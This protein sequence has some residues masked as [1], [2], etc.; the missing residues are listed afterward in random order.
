[1]NTH[2]IDQSI[3][4]KWE[5][6]EYGRSEEHVAVAP[7]SAHAALDEGLAMKLVSIRLPI[8]LIEGLKKIAE[9]H[10]IAYQPMVRDLLTRFAQSEV[11]EIIRGLDEKMKAV[12]AE[13]ESSPPVEAFM[14][15]TRMTACG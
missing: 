2:P 14:E 9:H 12:R 5:E 6:G 3:T 8:P 4:A 7:E 15:R 11:E 13:A 10:G 1:M